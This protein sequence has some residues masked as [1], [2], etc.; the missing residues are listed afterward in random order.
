MT[1]PAVSESQNLGHSSNGQPASSKALRP[2]HKPRWLRDLLRFLPLKS[3]FVLSGNV[4]DLQAYEVQPGTV[5]T[6]PLQAAI[7][8]ELYSAGYS[9]VLSIDCVRGARLISKTGNLQSPNDILTRIGC[10]S[11][12]QEANDLISLGAILEK[13]IFAEGPPI[14]V[15]VDFA[16]RLIV[17]SDSLSRDE[18]PFF[19][20]AHVFSATARARPIGSEGRPFFNTVIW[21]VDKEGDLPDWLLLGNPRIRHIPIAKPD[22]IARRSVIPA[23]LKTLPG[24]TAGSSEALSAAESDFVD[25]TEGLLLS[26]LHAIAQLGRS[27][28][29]SFDR[30]SDAVRRYKVGVTDDQWRKIDREKIRNAKNF[31][32]ERVRGQEHAVTHALDIIKRAITGVGASKRGGRPRGVTFLAGPTGVGKT[33]LAK[34]I[35]SLLFGDESAYIRFDMSEFSAEHSDQRLIG[36]PPGYVGYDVGGELT[37]AVR[38]KPFSVILFDEIEKAHPR[39]LDKFLQI[40]DDGVLT[41]GRGDRVYFSEAFIIFTS[42]LGIYRLDADGNRVLNVSQEEP[43]DAVKTKV[44]AEIERHFKSVLNRP[45]ILNRI[46]ENVIVFDFIR[47]AIAREIFEQ[48][49]SAT[50]RDLEATGIRVEIAQSV[51]EQLENICLADLSNGGRGIRNQVESHLVNPLSRCLFDN[52]AQ[53]GSCW[54]VTGIDDAAVTTLSIEQR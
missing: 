34:T 26:D 36:A 15:V 39:I 47:P 18:Q 5:S 41:S 50:L 51:C 52:D 27:E 49:V 40:L 22:N 4:Q 13:A 37:N 33:E 43:P 28:T 24:A 31:I 46:G 48:M 8:R 14:A 6:I 2:D 3:Q 1:Q 20:R 19:S 35:T 42:N 7:A 10:E 30:I 21:I 44:R 23:L 38:E 29:L 53:A 25:E 9:D 54:T 11:G 12:A 16:S 45:E 17:R 32:S